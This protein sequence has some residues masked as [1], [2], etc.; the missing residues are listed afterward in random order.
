M[1]RRRH[2]DAIAAS[3]SL[4]WGDGGAGA[5]QALLWRARAGGLGASGSEPDD[6]G[7]R[8]GGAGRAAVGVARGGPEAGAAAESA[9]QRRTL[10]HRE[11]DD[12]GALPGRL[13]HLQRGRPGGGLLRHRGRAGGAGQLQELERDAHP[14]S[15]PVLWRQHPSGRAAARGN[16]AHDEV[17]LLASAS[18]GRLCCSVSGPDDSYQPVRR[19][20]VEHHARAQAGERGG[21]LLLGRAGAGCVWAG[22]ACVIPR[23]VLRSQSD[24]QKKNREPEAGAAHS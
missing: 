12:R 15:V 13:H 5:R 1:P 17:V 7:G 8:A 11:Q 22:A 20:A 19:A 16:S 21:R 18:Q 10:P 3:R 14:E 2:G 4:L 9:A 6:A 24:Q 23:R